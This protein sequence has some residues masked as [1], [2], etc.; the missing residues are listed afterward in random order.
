M[1]MKKI[2]LISLLITGVFAQRTL[3]KGFAAIS[4]LGGFIPVGQKTAID[5]LSIWQLSMNSTTRIN[6]QIKPIT[7]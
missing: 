7:N 5:T 3:A 2:F 1:Y 6:Q 4:N